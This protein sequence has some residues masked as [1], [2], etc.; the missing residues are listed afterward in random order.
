[1]RS[2]ALTARAKARLASV[3]A[4]REEYE[5]TGGEVDFLGKDLLEMS[6]EDRAREGMFLAFQYPVEIPG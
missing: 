3:L 6:P 1:M 4:G 5:V 2:W